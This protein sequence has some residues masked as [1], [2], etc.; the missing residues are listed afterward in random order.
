VT[1]LADDPI[2][3]AR[4]F[5]ARDPAATRKVVRRVRRILAFRGYGIPEEDRRELEQVVIIQIWEGIRRPGFDPAGF[6]GFVEVV[7][8]RR[9]ID[10][11]RL[12]RA[13]VSL[14]DSDEVVDPT[15]SPLKS[16]IQREKTEIARETL[17][18][19]PEPCRQ[20]IELV[21]GQGKTYVEAAS[22]LGSSEGALRVRMHRC[23]REARKLLADRV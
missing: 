7:V 3:V 10:W 12:H 16:L 23:I 15:L 22:I 18:Q 1:D 4:L 13:E 8:S 21:V 6:W 17:A 19:L 5:A 20:V 9:C 2:S 11:L 14:E